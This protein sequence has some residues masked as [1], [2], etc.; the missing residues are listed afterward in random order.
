MTK[1]T[2]QIKQDLLE[3]EKVVNVLA[4][5]LQDLYQK[6]LESLS[7][8]AQKQLILVSYQICTQEYPQAFLNL[9]LEK[10]ENLQENLR[11]LGQEMG[12]CLIS[13]LTEDSDRTEEIEGFEGFEEIEG[14][15]ELA[16][17]EELERLEP[18]PK[19]NPEYWIEWHQRN[20][21]TISKTFEN[22]SKQANKLLK[23]TKIL[24]HQLPEKVMEMAIAAENTES[25]VSGYPNMLNMLIEAENDSEENDTKITKLTAIR[26]RLSEIEFSDPNLSNLGNQMRNILVK[27]NKL[28]K[29][30]RKKER[31]LLIA[32]AEASWRSTWYEKQ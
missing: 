32:E 3:F 11:K 4:I 24:P 30:Y 17:F 20:Q 18:L 12:D 16:E 26:L 22:I 9:S 27:I 14:F 10:R 8:S 6:Y 5:E 23:E 28:K 19:T 13:T 15:E 29:Q 25:A 7:N 1:S 21:Q 31:Q 2:Q